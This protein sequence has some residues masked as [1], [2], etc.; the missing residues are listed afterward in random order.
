[1][2][3]ARRLAKCRIAS[4]RWAG[5][6]RP[7]VQRV[8][9]CPSTRTA[10][11]PHT[12][13]PAGISN[14]GASGARRFRGGTPRTCG[15]T[16]P[17]RRTT[18]RS[19]TR[20]SLRTT[21]SWLCRVALGHRHPADEYR[22]KARH[23][24]QRSGPPHLDA[25]VEDNYVLD[26]NEV[27]SARTQLSGRLVFLFLERPA[28]DLV[29]REL[30]VSGLYDTKG[31][32]A[33]SQTVVL[34][35][36]M[37]PPKSVGGVVSGR[38][39]DA[40]GT[41]IE[42]ARV[43]YL[44]ST[45]AGGHIVGLAQH[46]TGAD[47]SYQ[48]DWVRRA[49]MGP[50]VIKA[51]DLAA[52]GF[53]ER[54]TRIRNH[55]EHLVVDLVM[56][57]R[58]G[59]T[60]IVTNLAAAPVPGA[61]VLVT[62]DIDQANW[63]LVETDGEGRYTATDILVGAVSVKAVS[64]T[65]S[66]LAA[67]N[68]QRAGTFATVDVTINTG[69]GSVVSRALEVDGSDVTTPVVRAPIFYLIPGGVSGEELIAGSGD[70]DE[71]G[72]FVFE[73]VPTGPFRIVAYD[74][75]RGTSASKTGELI[76]AGLDVTV[77]GCA[78]GECQVLFEEEA[79]G[80]IT[81]QIRLASGEP[82]AGAVVA[83]GG[84]QTVTDAAGTFTLSAVA[85]GSHRVSANQGPGRY[86]STPV[87]VVAGTTANVSLTLPGV[88]RVVVT[89]LDVDGS[90]MVGHTVIRVTSGCAGVP[91]VTDATGV[92]VFEDV[93]I[94]GG[95]FKAIRDNDIADGY[96]TVRSDAE[97]AAIALRFG[98]FG[99]VRGT[100]V[101]ADG[102]PVHG[103][104]VVLGAKVASTEYCAF[105][106][107]TRARQMRTDTD[108][109]FVFDNVPVGAVN[110]SASS[111]FLPIPAAASGNLLSHGDVK[112][113]N[114]TLT[115]NIAGELHGTVYLPDGTTRAGAGVQVTM[116]GGRP[117]VTVVT[118]AEGRYSFAKIFPAGRYTVVAADPVTGKVVKEWI[119]LQADQDLAADLRLLGQGTVAVTV[120]D[121]G[122]TPIEDAFVE[123]RG[124]RY[125]NY[126]SAGAVTVSD[127]GKIQFTKVPEGSFS[128]MASDDE[129]R[130]GR[131]HGALVEDGSTVD[132]TVH[133]TVT[134]TVSGT[135]RTSDGSTPIP[136]AEV[137][138][139]QG[140]GRFLGSTVT[141]SHP[142]S[143]GTFHFDFVP[144]GNV[145]VTAM[146]PLT[147]RLGEASGIIEKQDEELDLEILQLGS[148]TLAGTVT[149]GGSPMSA[150]EV[151]LVS[152]TGLSSAVPNL[153]AYATTD[154]AGAFTF[155]GVPVGRFDLR[156]TVD[157]LLLVG[158]E[159]GFIDTDGQ[160]ITD[161]EIELDAS[162]TLTGDILRPD[163]STLV[164]AAE[165]TI[166][167]SKGTIRTDA[168]SLGRYENAFVPVGF[169]DIEASDS[170]GPD[171][172]IA[173]GEL[174][175]GE[176]L[177]VDVIF[178][179]TGTVSGDA[180]DF[181]DT[182]L[183]TGTVR[184]TRSAPFA[185]DEWATVASD[186]TFQFFGIPVG[187]YN[188][189]LSVPG[190]VRRGAASGEITFDGETDTI[191]VKLADA[192]TVTGVVTKEVDGVT[193]APNA[194]VEVKGSGFMLSALTDA[195][196][197]FE[198]DGIPLGSLD[199]WANDPVTR[200]VAHAE[201]ELSTAGQH[202]DVGTMVL[203]TEP[204]RVESI[205][206]A[207]GS[208][209][210][211]DT[212]VV[213]RF[214][215][216]TSV[217]SLIGRFYVRR[218]GV[219]LAGNWTLSDDGLELV[220]VPNIGGAFAFPPR[221][222]IEVSLSGALADTFGRR[223]GE[224]FVSSFTTGSAVMVGTVFDGSVPAPGVDV[225]LI[226]VGGS[227][228]TTVTAADGKYRFENVA[229]GPIL[230]QVL[231][232]DGRGSSTSLTIE[233]D[234][235]LVTVDFALSY[236]G[237]VSGNV[238]DYHGAPMGAGHDVAVWVSTGTLATTVTDAAGNY[239]LSN[240]PVG[241]V[242]VDVTDPVTGN[243]GRASVTIPSGGSVAGNV[244]MQ[245]TGSLRVFVRDGDDA[246]VSTATTHINHAYLAV[247]NIAITE[248]WYDITEPEADG[249]YLF[250]YVNPG[251]Y[252]LTA[253]DTGSALVA[254]GFGSIAAGDE[255]VV[256]IVLQPAG[257][258]RAVVRA[259]DGETPFAGATVKFRRWNDVFARETALSD[260]AGEALFENVPVNLAP[261]VLEVEL[262]GRLRARVRDIAVTDGTET[263]VTLDISGLG[264]VGGAVVPPA[265][266]SLSAN[267]FVNL[268]SLAAEVGGVFADYDA[269]DGTYLITDVP[270]GPFTVTGR[271]Q[272]Q[273]FQGEVAGVVTADGEHVV[274]DIQLL[275]NG[276]TF[277][278][279]GNRLLDGNQAPYKI[280][281]DGRLDSDTDTIIDSTGDALNL[282]VAVNGG[283]STA[284]VGL[285]TGFE[286]ESG[287]EL[288]TS[289]QDIDGV[290]V[291]RKVFVPY[292]G[293]FSRHLEIFENQ[294]ASDVTVT[295]TLRSH[296]TSQ[297]ATYG[298]L[299]LTES[300]SGDA[301]ADETDAWLIFDDAKD[302]DPFE[303]GTTG[304]FTTA[305]VMAGPGSAPSSVDFAPSGIDGIL[306]TTYDVM[307][308]AGGQAVVMH[309]MAQS[310]FRDS[311]HEAATR[312]EQLPPEAL[313]GL[314]LDEIATITN[315]A[316]PA[317]GVSLVEPLPLL[318]GKVY[319]Q[320]LAHDGVTGVGP[321]TGA[322]TLQV[323]F[324][325][326]LI[327]YN[328]IRLVNA[329]AD[330]NFR[331]YPEYSSNKAVTVP[332][333]SYRISSSRYTAGSTVSASGSSDF[334]S[335]SLLSRSDDLTVTATSEFNA[336]LGPEEVVD[337]NVHSEWRVANGVA[338]ATLNMTFPV[339]VGIDK[340]RILPDSDGA[341][342]QVSIRF[343]DE[344]AGEIF[345][346]TKTFT[347][348]TETITIELDPEIV[349]VK[350]ISFVF[351]GDA[352]RV[353]EI[354]VYGSTI[355]DL[356]TSYRDLVFADSAGLRVRGERATGEGL[357]SS[358]FGRSVP[359]TIQ[360]IGGTTD[361][362]GV[363][364]LFRSASRRCRSDRYHV[365]RDARR[366]R[367]PIPDGDG[368]GASHARHDD[369]GHDR[370]SG[371]GLDHG[372]AHE[373]HG[374]PDVGQ[375]GDDLSRSG[376]RLF[377]NDRLERPL[378]VREPSGRHVLP[379][380]R[381]QR[382]HALR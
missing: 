157:G 46:V 327:L 376:L 202:L 27:V 25:D 5:Q 279:Y 147:G 78:D 291:R 272:F 216:P 84:L 271:D 14:R 269:E 53:Q 321:N 7:A 268:A 32:A 73:D 275:D 3:I 75:V 288:V 110:V 169:F 263:T 74:L 176:T 230:V 360:V 129:G 30:T 337:G 111:F 190:E 209:V 133:M 357:Q 313:F 290:R 237:S 33:T 9:A 41:P 219:N 140:T 171:A 335:R 19:P 267:V 287:R 344:T 186:G 6:R 315:F 58:G 8:A 151:R 334:V 283:T 346:T 26:A 374:R 372:T 90:P 367:P 1:M 44:N 134:G 113:F 127:N 342:D 255:L 235:G 115:S 310:S 50:F 377:P 96:A 101:D 286:E 163:A 213:V 222:T 273:D 123:L 195:D 196:G 23:R 106:R 91:V 72:L 381:C 362:D 249:S 205:T 221:S 109:V 277:S 333:D 210:P 233:P 382:P 104:D 302:E 49:D 177:E 351:D 170:V 197:R 354:F 349:N 200:G 64:G 224:N 251:W 245:G 156:A 234:D 270:V 225:T 229:E 11:A 93:P 308:P 306:T 325:S 363:Y 10:G 181:D 274:A 212:P 160:E 201:G 130:G 105:L 319:G 215:D 282:E 35:S 168:N 117:D 116:S 145:L 236:L 192:G 48:F 20:T 107:N 248:K 289:A 97:S 323:R 29:A 166:Q 350:Q 158:N 265:G 198:I 136:N 328:R 12:G 149:S 63:A 152:E 223:M 17:A 258:V 103:A 60:G 54:S 193:P 80:N 69:V 373:L 359:T 294:G 348:G 207:A 322:G 155:D 172:G 188:L 243:R 124:A 244:T 132:I 34:G 314:G 226:P 330:G 82:A 143:L 24:G 154:G 256:D 331:L 358:I 300:S 347:T 71:N 144:A 56:R 120:V 208:T 55:G 40:E 305:F 161:I 179:G 278:I 260:S 153:R 238:V 16:S 167:P 343:L 165:I 76:V 2:S 240:I 324:N 361:D 95:Y 338:T 299:A 36:R 368:A 175:E 292:D 329:D 112:D 118:D 174:A 85:A 182:L 276:L 220:K 369:G 297:S 241:P 42:G 52:S 185:R 146:D 102:D 39:L 252:R 94:P 264:S 266:E 311:S 253:T 18:T 86:A 62:S 131:E 37:V 336:S 79:V 99:T 284:F 307:V 57:G 164:P 28:G 51:Y 355:V 217:A 194:V 295:A 242:T 77:N 162:G 254:T 178:N 364:E 21:S 108:G 366:N 352:I 227:S 285:S 184:L 87:N 211:P 61:K 301:V 89:L 228:V 318:D 43:V 15:I 59:V 122:G 304:A 138:L 100:V 159:S 65:S 83:A 189:S 375:N 262:D 231:H 38:V 4:L 88:G 187:T 312:L 68:L 316:V 47:G 139:R 247:G 353:N 45:G 296:L 345:A 203:D 341:L 380:T 183:S 191:T 239:T 332:R 121:G 137:T 317:G 340:L 356:G 142:D 66:G 326:D 250:P 92:A 67:G 173:S 204:I 371:D 309:F 148:G 218:D 180:R 119:S 114:L 199:V 70:T 261:Y 135:Y 232:S 281:Q 128:V 339:T 298:D 320:L 303:S 126:Q 98:G 293:Y 259:P 246:I 379:A 125:P 13:H 370:L 378:R 150:A 214:T 257:S 81:G 365:D 141:S 206:P 22:L 280:R 31:S